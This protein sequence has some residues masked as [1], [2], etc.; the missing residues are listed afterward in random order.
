MTGV[1][2]GWLDGLTELHGRI[3]GRF[4]RSEPRR[5]AFAYLKGLLAG[6]ERKNGWTL[7]EYA[8]QGCPDGMQRL[9]RTAGWC[10]DAVRDD[11]RRYV[12][13]YLGGPRGVLIVD[14]T[15]FIKKGRRSA[16]VQRQYTGTS[17]KIDN[18]QLGVFCAYASDAG[19]AL[20]DRELYLPK[21]WTSDA[22]R[23]RD[24]GIGE[25]VPFATKTELAKQ[26]I[27]RSL[28][29]GLPVE[30]FTADEAY[31]S[32]TAL[33]HWLEGRALPYVVACRCN[34]RAETPQWGIQTTKAL[35]VEG[36]AALDWQRL[37]AGP[38]AHGLR[39]FDWAR[40]D[41][42]PGW[43]PDWSRWLLV[44]RSLSDP[45]E[46]AYYLCAGPTGTTLAELV[47]VAGSRWAVEECFQQAK[48]E[49][50][51]DQYQVRTYTAWYRHITLSMA[52]HAYLAVTRAHA[53]KGALPVQ[54]VS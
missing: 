32:D 6:L 31:G 28:D 53:Q 44:R 7:A 45:T 50:G 39:L 18:C 54:T 43:R 23:C 17:G 10:A 21:S 51:L 35:V 11:L 36:V 47:R 8:G 20:I 4:G 33:R 34:D 26:M 12:I 52:A 22:E 15:G 2:S 30:W 19:H 29:A 24:A 46:L 5:R 16:G 25:D 38:G 49:A 42:L 13:E 1:D 27:A 48:N 9:L 41:L 37:S 3:A 40:L 14:E